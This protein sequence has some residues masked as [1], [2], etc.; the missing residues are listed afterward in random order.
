AD[1]FWQLAGEAAQEQYGAFEKAVATK[2]PDANVRFAAFWLAD[3]LPDGV[4]WGY[5]W[6]NHHWNEWLKQRAH[7][8]S[9][10]LLA[11]NPYMLFMLLDVYQTYGRL[12]ANR[13]QL[14][15]QFVE[16]LLVR[17][18]LLRWDEAAKAVVSLPDGEGLLTALT[19]L[20]F[21]LQTRRA[22][23]D[24]DAA[25]LTALPLAEVS[26][27]LSAERQYQAVSANLLTIGRDVRFSHQLL[28]EYFAARAMRQRIFPQSADGTSIVG[29][30]S[31]SFPSRRDLPNRAAKPLQAAEIWPPGRW[32]EPTNWEE[33]TILLAGLFSDN[34][35][36]VLKWAA[37]AQPEV[38]A[39]CIVESGAHTPEESK[40]YLRQRW[41]PRLT[42]LRR[43]PD[44]RARAAV[45]RALGRITMADGTPLD[46]RPGVGF[47]LQDGRKIPDIVWGKEVPAGR[48][49]IGGDKEAYQ[50]FDKQQVA[51]EFPYR[52]AR[53][54][55]TCAQFDC[56]ATAL[57]VDDEQ[58]WV[59][60]PEKE[61]Q[62]DTPYF[63]P[64]T[65]SARETV[66]WYQAVA[67]CRWL[68]DKLGYKMELPH[69][70]EWEA[71][72]RWDGKE[73]DGRF[74]PWGNQFDST[75]ANTDEGDN[76]GQ[77]TAVG[78][79]P[80][81]R[82][83]ELELYDLSGNVW[84]WQRNKYENPGDEQIDDSNARR[85]LRGGSWDN[86]RSSARAAYRSYYFP[87]YRFYDLGFR[88]VV[89]RRPPSQ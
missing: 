65:N 55:I 60:M 71:A 32:W 12:P 62:I 52:L 63:P 30:F 66:S 45:G 54:P 38:A 22:G 73:V 67:F 75:K 50:S 1:L 7:P 14:F 43:D 40:I 59:G 28:Q 84:E 11:T 74:Y 4:A 51:I 6:D 37:D 78:L 53:Y 47:T 23:Q 56:F 3:T 44:A 24:G 83:K 77:T 79:Y 68:S 10:L 31:K 48:Y 76:V 20:A 5:S 35:T 61:R 46:N 16:T 85:V 27:Y 9:L 64:Y 25:A 2:L 41:L 8:A 19:A 33:A 42:D 21:A 57:D 17:E 36:P 70:Y 81:G 26:R 13:G 15:D 72:A 69:E 89:V 82:S 29:R 88:V 58:W 39:R 80:S 18:G 34:C 49:T 87:D 86:D